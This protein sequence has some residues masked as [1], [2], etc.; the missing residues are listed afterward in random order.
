[1]SLCHSGYEEEANKIVASLIMLCNKRFSQKTTKWFTQAAVE[2]AK[3]QI[4]DRATNTIKVDKTKL[5]TEMELFASFGDHTTEV[6]QRRAQ[7]NG[8]TLPVYDG[9]FDND[10]SSDDESESKPKTVFDLKMLFQL[11]PSTAA[12]SGMNNNNSIGTCQTDLT[13]NTT[14]IQEEANNT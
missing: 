7:V 5:N 10:T 9:G 14:E 6:V 11:K 13:N 8:E 12:A 1:M 3:I 4:Y 2:E